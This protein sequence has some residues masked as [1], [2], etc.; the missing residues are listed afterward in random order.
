MLA[1]FVLCILDIEAN[2][3]YDSANQLYQLYDS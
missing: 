3:S 2:I 1:I